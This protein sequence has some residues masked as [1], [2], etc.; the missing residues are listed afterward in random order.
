G[1]PTTQVPIDKDGNVRP[2]GLRQ[3]MGAYEF[4][5]GPQTATCT[6]TDLGVYPT[7]NNDQQGTVFISGTASGTDFCTGSQ[8][9]EYYC[10]AS[11]S[12]SAS[13]QIAACSNGCLNGACIVIDT[14]PPMISNIQNTSIT[15]NSATI[16]WTTDESSSSLA[17][18][19]TIPGNYPTEITGAIGTSHSVPLTG[20]SASTLY[21]YVVNSTD[22]AGNSAQSMENNFMTSSST[23][24]NVIFTNPTPLNNSVLN[25]NNVT[26]NVSITSSFGL[27]KV[28]LEINGNNYTTPNLMGCHYEN[29][30]NCDN[31][32]LG[33]GSGTTFSPGIFGQ[34]ILIDGIDSLT[35]SSTNNINLGEGTVMF[36]INNNGWLTST[37]YILL[38][39]YSDT[40]ATGLL[41]WKPTNTDSIRPVIY[42]NVGGPF[43][44]NYPSTSLLQG[45]WHHIAVTYGN[46]N[47]SMYLDGY[48]VN[49][50]AYTGSI[51]AFNTNIYVG[52]RRTLT[53]QANSVFDE[54][55]TYS[56]RLSSEE[57]SRVYN[58][59]SGSYY[60]KLNNLPNGAYAI[61]ATAQDVN[62]INTV[63][64]TRVFTVN[65]VVPDTQAPL[66]SGIIQPQQPIN[67]TRLGN[68][69]FNI[70]WTDNSV[71]STVIIEHNFNGA[72]R[73]VTVNTKV[74]NQYY[75][76]VS[77]IAVGNYLYR[78]SANDSSG[79]L[80]KTIPIVF[81]ID[82]VTPRCALTFLPLFVVYYPNLI[83][84]TG[85]CT[86]S[87]NLMEYSLINPYFNLYR[88]DINGVLMNANNENSKY[89]LL[90]PGYYSYIVNVSDTYNFT[91]SSAEWNALI[92]KTLNPVYLSLNGFSNNLTIL[93]NQTLN[94]TASSSS[95]NFI[96]YR[97]GID[98]T[99]ESGTKI[100]LPVGYYL[101]EV[102]SDGNQ[103]YSV[104]DTGVSYYV[105]VTQVSTDTIAPSYSN[106][107]NPTSNVYARNR[108]Y[109][110]NVTWTDNYALSN[111]V[112]ENNFDGILR[113]VT[114]ISSIGGQ[115]YFPVN[116]LAAGNYIYKWYAN[117]T[118]GNINQTSLQTFTLNKAIPTCSLQSLPSTTVTFPST[119][120]V[121]G[122]CL[123]SE[124][125]SNLYRGG[126]NV[127][128]EGGIN[129]KLRAGTYNYIANISSSANYTSSSATLIVTVLK[130]KNSIKLLMNG[131]SSNL[132]ITDNQ[133][134][135]ATAYSDS[136]N[137]NL[138]RNQQDITY[139]SG[140]ETVLSIGS[141]V[142]FAN[143]SG[144]ENFTSNN[145]G[146]SLFVTVVSSA[147]ITNCNFSIV[148]NQGINLVSLPLVPVNNS[149]TSIFGQILGNVRSIY[150]YNAST[151]WGVYY[152][153]P[154]V[155][156]TLSTIEPRRAYFVM[157]NNSSSITINGN[158]NNANGSYPVN[159]LNPGWNLIGIH[160]LTSRTVQQE[161]ENYNVSQVWKLNAT[162]AYE[163][164]TNFNTQIQPGEGYWFYVP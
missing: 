125:Q 9:T 22:A 32:V 34:G 152:P 79:N 3:D 95:G 161:I 43:S 116:D 122:S 45:T 57:I 80:N 110:F 51:T 105:N 111:V 160:N 88:T 130:G 107:I 149:I 30:Y 113:N 27:N 91:Y 61:N 97:N 119:I 29:I 5:S 141:Y 68:Y 83:N 146:P 17:K 140:V 50:T 75:F 153:N 42:T 139:L 63:S 8:L 71:L 85:R 46:G 132:T 98:V 73:N 117:D 26:L 164:I 162:N 86:T 147:C 155:P 20:L 150:S 148:L 145:T 74:G 37:G 72:L 94:A 93:N 48:P 92:L 90:S 103:N 135:N 16:T 41:F 84:V 40:T 6:D 144:D 76:A 87:V 69:T 60:L 18:Y 1:D 10:L 21:Y 53:F 82:K 136:E 52:S 4:G 123:P 78:W 2:N 55:K 65:S 36:W 104:N 128:N 77:D 24:T 134:I 19:G 154:G 70:T 66:Y 138:Y 101:Y 33:T 39:T 156:S 131:V 15:Q 159:P 7:I 158:T 28:N 126:I 25:N 12:T 127:N 124:I 59:E 120:N 137:Y 81:N 56:K 102:F 157:M 89:V 112:L 163:R 151:G 96:M 58:V 114:V 118:S 121:T 109:Y 23:P 11:T 129:V 133:T 143:S 99:N 54:F 14:T 115:Y 38:D 106:I 100:N 142:F 35:Y 44:I 108:T 64:E 62:N 49:S 47:F 13:T 31:S 67:Y